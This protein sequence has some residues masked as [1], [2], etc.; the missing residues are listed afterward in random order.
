MAPGPPPLPA[1]V[2]SQQTLADPRAFRWLQAFPSAAMAGV[3]AAL[4]LIVGLARLGGVGFGL[5]VFAGALSVVFYRKR[6][7]LSTVTP[8]IGARVGVL[9]GAVG[10]VILGIFIALGMLVPKNRV[11][12]RD[13][14]QQ[15][16]QRQMQQAGAG[17]PDPGS[18]WVMDFAKTPQ[19]MTTVL[20]ISFAFSL[21]MVVGL[22]SLG[23]LLGAVALRR[24]DHS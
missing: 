17:Q 2:A 6:Q 14:L 5:S 24:R 11:D 3:V 22:C 23:G 20:I 15:Q 18:Q 21:V 12:L 10:A 9:C 13:Q 1:F 7:P 16:M 19:G 8:A 4:L